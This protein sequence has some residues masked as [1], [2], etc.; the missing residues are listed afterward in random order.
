MDVLYDGSCS[1]CRAEVRRLRRSRYRN[2]MRFVDG[3][4]NAD[5]VELL[6]R[7]HGDADGEACEG[8]QAIRSG[9]AGAGYGWLVAVTRVPGVTHGLVLG[10]RAIA[11]GLRGLTRAPAVGVN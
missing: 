3:R 5:L 8:V 9:D 7:V 11:R 10:Y 6:D 1:T 2:A 4:D